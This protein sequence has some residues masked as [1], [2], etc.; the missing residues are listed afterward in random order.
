M[1][2]DALNLISLVAAL[3]ALAWFILV[4]ALLSRIS[5]RLKESV[6]HLRVITAHLGTR[7]AQPQ[8][9]RPVSN[10]PGI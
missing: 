4:L 1:D 9:E 10:D 5:E 8:P 2:R 6:A 3:A 7:D